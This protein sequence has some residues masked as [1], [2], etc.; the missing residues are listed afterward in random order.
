[1]YTLLSVIK[2]KPGNF[3]PKSEKG[4]GISE[5]LGNKCN[6]AEVRENALSF[7]S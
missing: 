6:F 4:Q 3:I 5:K 1:M 7:Y 2:E